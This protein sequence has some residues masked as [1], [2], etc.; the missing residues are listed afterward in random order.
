MKSLTSRQQEILEFIEHHEWRNGFWPSIREIQ[1][2][3]DFRSTNAVM[4]HLRALE[5]KGVLE[6]ILGQARTFRIIRP[7]DPEA[8]KMPQ[9]ATEVVE[10]PVVGAIA[11]G[12]PD[13]VESAGEIGRA[14]KLISP[15]QA[16]VAVA[17]VLL[18]RYGESMVD[19]EIY[20]GDMVVIE[21]RE[22]KDGDIVAALIDQ[23]Q[24]SNATSINRESPTS[25]PR[26]NSIRNYTPVMN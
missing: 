6:R 7:D 24:P 1:E 19:A 23:K 13:R 17:V 21:P 11:A 26:I 3:F 12:Y 20:D 8:V 4:G 22:P 15:A 5:R 16:S 2:R 14:F 10:A 18:C 9:D 25:K